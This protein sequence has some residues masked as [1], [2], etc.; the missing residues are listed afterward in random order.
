MT[1]VTLGCLLVGSSL[2]AQAPRVV[3]VSVAHGARTY[4][5]SIS[6]GLTVPKKKP[7]SLWFKRRARDYAT[8]INKL[9]DAVKDESRVFSVVVPTGRALAGVKRQTKKYRIV[10]EQLT[11]VNENLTPGIFGVDALS[12]MADHVDEYL[13]FR[14]DHHWTALGAYYAYQSLAQ[15][16]GFRPLPLEELERR[17]Q[18]KFFLGSIY[19]RNKTSAMRRRPDRVAYYIPPVS[20]EGVRYSRQR[21]KRATA[22]PFLREKLRGYKMFLGGD[23]P[24]MIAHTSVRNGKSV[25][26]VKNSYGNPFAIFLLA[27]YE[28]VVVVDYRYQKRALAKLVKE[29]EIDD[30]VFL[31]VSSLSASRSHQRHLRTMLRDRR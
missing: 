26:L 1:L 24:L 25:M 21:P 19:R 6:S 3:P 18:S 9:Y 4:G 11:T 17:V 7:V 5:V 29:H 27:H 30:L 31:N 8:V 23:H 2:Y 20:H 16:A 15:A 28:H 12:S 14:T 13:Y 10:H 22:S